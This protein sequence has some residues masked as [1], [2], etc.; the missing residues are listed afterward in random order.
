MFVKGRAEIIQIIKK[1]QISFCYLFEN[2]R[3]RFIKYWSDWKLFVIF[4]MMTS[5]NFG[6]REIFPT[7]KY[8]S[9]LALSCSNPSFLVICKLEKP[10]I[11]ID[12]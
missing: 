9:K 5:K 7:L 12:K 11:Q 6:F 3:S 10:I 4:F 1:N 8:F 2:L